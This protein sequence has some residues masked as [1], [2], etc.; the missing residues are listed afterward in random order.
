MLQRHL[1][2]TDGL[3]NARFSGL[4]ATLAKGLLTCLSSTNAV[5]PLVTGRAHVWVML[6]VRLR[7]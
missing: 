6:E 2:H 4:R 7:E 1:P 3:L 5:L